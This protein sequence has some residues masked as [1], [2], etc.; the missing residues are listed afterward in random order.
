MKRNGVGAGVAEA[1]GA[2]AVLEE[3]AG[4]A[5]VQKSALERA[6]PHGGQPRA[7]VDPFLRQGKW[8]ELAKLFGKRVYCLRAPVLGQDCSRQQRLA[9]ARSRR[10][11]T[12]GQSEHLG[13]AD[14]ASPMQCEGSK[15]W[16]RGDIERYAG[17]VRPFRFVLIAESGEIT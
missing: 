4:L 14:V 5:T 6:C 12:P 10:T 13:S 9:S 3:E 15:G 8:A 7:L 11:V 2:E 16:G 1:C 17:D